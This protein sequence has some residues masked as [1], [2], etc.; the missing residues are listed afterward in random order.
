MG[1]HHHLMLLLLVMLLQLMMMSSRR[2][3][4]GCRHGAMIDA[5][6]LMT[7]LVHDAVAR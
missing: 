6:T 4:S 7:L 2:G 3:C 5:D 1:G